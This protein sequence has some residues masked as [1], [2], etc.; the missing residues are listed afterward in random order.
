L[1]VREKILLRM[2]MIG[3]VY[4]ASLLARFLRAVSTAT[5]TGLPLPQA[6]RLSAQAT[7]SET[8]TGDAER[9][10]SEVESGESIFVASQ[11][12]RIIPPLFGFC[13]QVAVGR[14]ALP[15]AIAQLAHAY[16]NRAMHTQAM[17]RVTLFPVLII[18]LGGFL[19]FGVTAMFLP[20]VHLINA[21][22][23]GG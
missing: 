19:L 22:S 20:L 18:F 3:R 10:A 7:G 17:L 9:L 12:T 8:L 16:E 1:A 14:D 5:A 15:T 13:V 23:A 11:A 6:M 21:V 4:R 2:P